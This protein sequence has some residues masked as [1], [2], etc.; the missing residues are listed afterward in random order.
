MDVKEIYCVSS[1]VPKSDE[2]VA[3]GML[4]QSRWE[5]HRIYWEHWNLPTIRPVRVSQ[6]RTWESLREQHAKSFP[7]GEY[8][9][10]WICT[11][12]SNSMRWNW[13]VSW[14]HE[15]HSAE[16]DWAIGCQRWV[17]VMFR[18]P[19][20]VAPWEVELI[21]CNCLLNKEETHIQLLS[22]VHVCVSSTC[23]SYSLSFRVHFYCFVAPWPFWPILETISSTL[24]QG[25][26]CKPHYNCKHLRL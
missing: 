19:C 21:V 24:R 6:T 15:W 16:E 7:S 9:S 20:F 4:N 14:F 13:T 5:D 25:L 22:H 10:R 23:G 17:R 12:L 11:W 8:F 3:R 26:G 1:A 2:S 18:L